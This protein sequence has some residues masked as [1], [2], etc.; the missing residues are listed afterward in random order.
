MTTTEYKIVTALCHASD[1]KTNFVTDDGE[2][3]FEEVVTAALLE[4]G[5]SPEGG[6]SIQLVSQI[7]PIRM[8]CSQAISRKVTVPT[9]ERKK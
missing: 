2:K 7:Q 6:I 5:G 1:D 3:P 8:I 9:P 4:F